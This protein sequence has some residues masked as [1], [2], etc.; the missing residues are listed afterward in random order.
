VSEL[1]VALIAEGPTDRVIIESALRAILPAPFTLALLQP[2]PTHPQLGSG[3]CGVFKWCRAFAART[4]SS[5]ESDPTLPDFD[6]F[7]IHVDADV[8][9]AHYT[10]GGDKLAAAAQGLPSLPSAKPCPPA[11]AAAD[12]IRACLRAWLGLAQLGSHTVLCVPAKASEAWLAAGILAEADPLLVG[13]ECNLN[14]AGQ[15]AGRPVK[16]R[17]KKTVREYSQHAA[18]LTKNWAMVR[19]RCTQADRFSSEVQAAVPKK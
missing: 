2:E 10:D 15:L 11:S 8:A 14:V 17:I 13:L 9:E 18:T 4:P 1:R 5:L 3:W 7:V 16:Q 12:E 19:R 6:L